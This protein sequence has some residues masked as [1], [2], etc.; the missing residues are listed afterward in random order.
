ML[1]Q[2]SKALARLPVLDLTQSRSGPPAL[3]Q[4][5]DW[6]ANVI[7]IEPPAHLTSGEG[8][9]GPRE[10]PDFQNL[11]RNKRSI[12]LNLKEPEGIEAFRRLVQKADII[13][14]NFR[15][16]VKT[17]LKIDYEKIGR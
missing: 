10:G 8:P 13:V 12:T 9:G 4:P 7:K 1:P 6:G 17:R 16:D 5:A 11:H 15:P 14:E 2:S 3:R